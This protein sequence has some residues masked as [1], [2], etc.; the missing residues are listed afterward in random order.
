[1]KKTIFIAHIGLDDKLPPNGVSIKNKHLHN[2]LK[3][4]TDLGIIDTYSWKKNPISV[5]FKIIVSLFAASKIIISVNMKNANNVV[6]LV[7]LLNK[8]YDIKRIFK[9][10]FSS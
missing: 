6:R 2:Y 5:L 1:M 7:R 3:S 8:S 9:C 4:R 10:D